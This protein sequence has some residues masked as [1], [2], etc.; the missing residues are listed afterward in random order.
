[1]ANPYVQGKRGGPNGMGCYGNMWP[2]GQM[3]H[4][5]LEDRSVI[6]GKYRV[7]PRGWNK[8]ANPRTNAASGKSKTLAPR[9]RAYGPF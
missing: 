6:K 2:P 1:M 8:A 3:E 4:P 9:R 7:R 5:H